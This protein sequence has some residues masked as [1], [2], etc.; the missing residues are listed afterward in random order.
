[1][2][3][4]L[5]AIVT[6]TLDE[7]LQAAWRLREIAAQV[8]VRT[9]TGNVWEP[10]D[11]ERAE[12][13]AEWAALQ[14]RATE[15][16]AEAQAEYEAMPVDELAEYIDQGWQAYAECVA[17]ARG[18]AAAFGDGPAGHVH[19]DDAARRYLQVAEAVLQ[20]A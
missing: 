17:E 18:E 9:Y 6:M 1:M 14:A 15:L 8:G 2:A 5:A 4:T 19:H 11:A 3:A 16:L 20:A 12:L 10:T 7:V 13:K